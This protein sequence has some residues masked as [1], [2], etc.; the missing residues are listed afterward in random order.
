M[1]QSELAFL[2]HIPTHAP[3]DWDSLCLHL[4]L[5][6]TLDS[7]PD[8]DDAV[9]H[10]HG[11]RIVW[12][13]QSQRQQQSNGKQQ[14]NCRLYVKL[15]LRQSCCSH[16]ASQTTTT[17]TKGQRMLHESADHETRME[18]KDGISGRREFLA[19]PWIASGR[20]RSCPVHPEDLM[21]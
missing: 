12:G 9:T 18:E 14:P 5:R 2:H 7:R 13:T 19:G 11:D 4:R 16:P 10:M 6:R 1:I 3:H 20:Q 15:V 8:D 21:Y 17:K